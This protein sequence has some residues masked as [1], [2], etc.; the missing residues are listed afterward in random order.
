[1]AHHVFPLFLRLNI[2]LQQGM[3]AFAGVGIGTALMCHGHYSACYHAFF[4]FRGGYDPLPPLTFPTSVANGS[5]PSGQALLDPNETTPLSTGFYAVD[6]DITKCA[7]P[8]IG[9]LELLNFLDVRSTNR[10]VHHTINVVQKGES[11]RVADFD[12]P[13]LVSPPS[14]LSVKVKASFTDLLDTSS[15]WLWG[16]IRSVA[17]LCIW[18]VAL[19]SV[20]ALVSLAT[21]F[22][23]FSNPAGIL[24][25]ITLVLRWFVIG[26]V[27]NALWKCSGIPGNIVRRT[28][29]S[30]CADRF[31]ALEIENQE[32]RKSQIN[33]Q[34]EMKSSLETLEAR[35]QAQIPAV[36]EEM[37]SRRED[38]RKDPQLL[39][40]S[41]ANAEEIE[42]LQ[43]EN[44]KL[45][46]EVAMI[47]DDI[48][49]TV[50]GKIQAR[51]N[52]L[53]SDLA[54]VK[55]AADAI[56]LVPATAVNI[57]SPLPSRLES[58][59]S[60]LDDVKKTMT[61]QRT[62]ATKALKLTVLGDLEMQNAFGS[63]CQSLAA[64]DLEGHMSVLV[65]VL[66]QSQVNIRGRLARV[67]QQQNFSLSLGPVQQGPGMS[68]G[69]PGIQQYQQRQFAQGGPLGFNAP[70]GPP[71]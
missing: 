66:A 18:V 37:N 2:D 5:M 44:I 1:M 61:I 23:P 25:R 71:Y 42:R 8:G 58:V 36:C 52:Q 57:P 59:S 41:K 13:L 49:K 34:A 45:K 65:H 69:Y 6:N 50:R 28:V 63:K 11:V 30:I 64:D 12:L 46:A 20:A 39:K 51:L 9:D 54:A 26:F 33:L 68:Q 67:Q 47:K 22:F 32:L 14:P 40:L 31:K 29:V 56:S 19:S 53:T 55:T 60:V 3:T 62:A 70:P 17:W 48:A 35:L 10:S 21:T 24:A 38:Q 4:G 16:Y 15:R 7:R 27:W 43:D